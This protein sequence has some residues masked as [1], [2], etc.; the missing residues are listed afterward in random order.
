MRTLKY[1]TA[2]PG[3]Y[4]NCCTRGACSTVGAG[5][6]GSA[7]GVK[8]LGAG[9]GG[10]L[11][12]AVGV[13]LGELLGAAEEGFQVGS[14]LGE[15]VGSCIKKSRKTSDILCYVVTRVY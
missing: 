7:V 5:V 12:S 11:G 9:V 3:W 14:G 2:T 8:V 15:D 13:R 6:V 1:C 4:E 10:G